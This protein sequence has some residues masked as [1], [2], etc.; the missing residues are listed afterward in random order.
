MS[1]PEHP[2]TENPYEPPQAI[3][4]DVEKRHRRVGL[5]VL[6]V[7]LVPLAAA[8]AGYVTCWA[9]VLPASSM[10]NYPNYGG[11]M[12]VGVLGFLVGAIAAGYGAVRL[13]MSLSK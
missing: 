13:L 10:F 5:V 3:D 1:T 8:I 9:V 2:D 6:G 7:F 11:L 12:V 4:V